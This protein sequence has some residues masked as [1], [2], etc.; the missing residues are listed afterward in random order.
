VGQ[1]I[2]RGIDV[3]IMA[4]ASGVRGLLH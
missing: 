1:T 2:R 4:R 3:A